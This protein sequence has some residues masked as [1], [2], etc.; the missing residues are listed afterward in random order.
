MTFSRCNPIL[1]S[2]RRCPYAIRARLALQIAQ[3]DCKLREV[4]LRA[5]PKSML[6]ASSKGT[7][8]VFILSTGAVLEESLDIVAWAYEISNNSRLAF[9][10]LAEVLI[11]ENDGAFKYHLDRYKYPDRYSPSDEVEHRNKA[12][13][14][15]EEL[16]T[17]LMKSAWLCGTECCSADI[18]IAPFVRQFASVD[19]AWFDA[20]PWPALWSWLEDFMS[21]ELFLQV[22]KKY[23]PWQEADVKSIVFPHAKGSEWERK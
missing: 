3:I 6:V 15:L 2:F 8:P 21:S 23:A 22:M 13:L 14:F 10:S 20:Q 19:R 12:S 5:K 17:R 4:V 11:A 16:N 18:A 1:Y 7:V 9:P